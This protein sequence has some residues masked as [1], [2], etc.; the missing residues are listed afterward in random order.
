MSGPPSAPVKKA[1]VREKYDSRKPGGG[2]VS[3][4]QMGPHSSSQYKNNQ[5]LD[6]IDSQNFSSAASMA[7]NIPSA[8]GDST[9]QGNLIYSENQSFEGMS[10]G[11]PPRKKSKA[12][13]TQ[14][15][16]VGKLGSNHK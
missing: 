2:K 14:N 15:S 7:R 10:Y 16:L 9:S 8:T 6:S 11:A 1:S 12:E 4:S 3:A 13:S 5:K